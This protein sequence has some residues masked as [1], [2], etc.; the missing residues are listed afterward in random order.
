MTH[1]VALLRGI[2][3]GGNNIIKMPDLKASFAA[4]D[5]REVTTYIQSGNVVFE[6][7]ETK[8]STLAARIEA[9]LSERFGYQSRIVLRSH[10]QMRA[11]VGKAPAGFGKQPEMYRYDVVF[12]REPL[13]APEAMRDIPLREGVDQAF[14]G[15]GV[16]YFARL[17][18]RATQ[19][20]MSRIVGTPSYKSMTI[21]NWNT[22]VK[23]LALLDARV[24]PARTRSPDP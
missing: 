11:I 1:Y 22:T 3:V 7:T 4:L 14:A 12:L 21:R 19:S 18:S 23:L 13:S 6:A 9:G 5:L 17:I 15:D 8:P 10:G 24:T 20:Y 16:C 2:N